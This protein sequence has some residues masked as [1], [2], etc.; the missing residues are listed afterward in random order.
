MTKWRDTKDHAV[1]LVGVV[2]M[3]LPLW[4][5]LVAATRTGDIG[6][7]P[8]TSL[9]DNLQ[10]LDRRLE[11]AGPT[12]AGMLKVSGLTAFGV[13]LA[14]T[15]VSYLAA[16][17]M[18][19][20]KVH[21]AWFWVSLATLYFPIEARMIATFEVAATLGL[22]N[23]LTGLVFPILPL[24]VGTFAFRQQLKSMAPELM[25]AARL[26]AAGPFRFL[27]DFAVPLS[28]PM[29][30]AV[31]AISFVLGWNQFLWPLMVSVDNSQFTLMRGFGLVRSGSGAS[32]VL[33]AI[34]L[35]PPLVLLTIAMAWITRAQ[36]P[37]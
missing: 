12:L 20:C 8:G 22:H 6:L 37:R 31:F 26:D 3:G 32:F 10:S 15:V 30:G 16:Y 7:V 25:E 1:L 28:L 35:L 17:V 33:A 27:R 9:A 14:C 34:S 24:A 4:L 36:K 21:K 13:A 29:I 11:A 2:V 5:A 19:F 18:V 23:T